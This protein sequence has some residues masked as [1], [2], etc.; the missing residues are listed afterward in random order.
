MGTAAVAVSLH[1]H[2][3]EPEAFEGWPIVAI[4]EADELRNAC[5]PCIPSDLVTNLVVMKFGRMRKTV[6]VT[7]VLMQFIGQSRHS[8][9]AVKVLQEKWINSNSWSYSY[10]LE[11]NQNNLTMGP[12]RDYG[13]AHVGFDSKNACVNE[14]GLELGRVQQSSC[15]S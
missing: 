13:N 6:G 7:H 12:G 3:D 15:E 1:E 10:G 9:F 11:T 14:S 2:D 4:A 5:G 8:G